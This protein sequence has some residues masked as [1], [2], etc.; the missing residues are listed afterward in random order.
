[1]TD[2]AFTVLVADDDPSQLAYL[3]GLIRSLRPEWQVVAE[4]STAAQVTQQLALHEPALAV[5]D[6]RFADTTAIEVVRELRESYPVIFVTGDPLFAADAF[7]CDAIDFVLKPLRAERLE[8]ALRKAEGVALGGKKANKYASSLR[9]MRGHELVWTPL[10]E[11][12]YFE[13]QRKYTRVVA[14]DQEGL[15]KLGIGSTVKYLDGATFWRIHRRTV[16]NVAHMASAKRDEM[17]RLYVRLTDRSERLL[18]SRPYEHL[19]R[20]GFC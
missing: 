2:E 16:V 9:M 11:V 7:S 15:L 1:M 20:D 4:V 8:Q 17:G 14:K 3:S 13:A 5:L 10:S 12:R 19:F 18:V 6:V